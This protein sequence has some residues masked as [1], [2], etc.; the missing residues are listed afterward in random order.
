MSVFRHALPNLFVLRS[1]LHSKAAL[2]QAA[3]DSE[4]LSL[5]S[6]SAEIK[7]SIDQVTFWLHLKHAIEF[8]SHSQT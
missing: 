2:V 3:S 7:E 8:C 6:K 1:T 4:W 5:G